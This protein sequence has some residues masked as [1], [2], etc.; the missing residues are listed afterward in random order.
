MEFFLKLEA[1]SRVELYHLICESGEK[2]TNIFLFHPVSLCHCQML[3]VFFVTLPLDQTGERSLFSYLF[4]LMSFVCLSS[5]ISLVLK[6]KQSLF[7]CLC[8]CSR[9]YY[10]CSNLEKY[11]VRMICILIEPFT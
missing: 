3:Q 10:P 5:S 7:Y 11:M 6:L 4:L 2:K 1:F 8:V 9:V